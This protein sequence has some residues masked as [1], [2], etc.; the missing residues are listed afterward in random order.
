MTIDAMALNVIAMSGS[1]RKASTN[2]GLLRAAAAAHTAT[3]ETPVKFT[4]IDIGDL[5]LLY[6]QDIDVQDAPLPAVAAFQKEIEAADAFIIACPEHN[7][8]VSSALKNA[9]DWGPPSFWAGK[10]TG[11]VGAGGGAGTGRAQLALRQIGVFLDLHFVN[12]PE[13][14]IARFSEKCFNE[15]TGDLTDDKWK[16]RVGNMLDRTVALAPLLWHWF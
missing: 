16:Q 4:I 13:V 8:S 11:I 3:M 9:L 7:Y 6:N 1:L 10:A 15:E 14:Q 2:T 12:A 5:P